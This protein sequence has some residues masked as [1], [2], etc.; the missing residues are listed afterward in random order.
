ETRREVEALSGRP[1]VAVRHAAWVA[2]VRVV[3]VL[4]LAVLAG[5][6]SVGRL[7]RHAAV[8][9]DVVRRAE[10]RYPSCGVNRQEIAGGLAAHGFESRAEIE[11]DTRRD[12]PVILEVE[13]GCVDVDDGAF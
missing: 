9:H 2:D 8:A 3:R 5:I 10:P 11:A 6:V 12:D 13:R 7:Q 1:G 4:R